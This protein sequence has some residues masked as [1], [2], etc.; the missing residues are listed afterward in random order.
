VAK[1]GKEIVGIIRENMEFGG[2]AKMSMLGV[3]PSFRGK[4]IGK[5][6]LKEFLRDLENK[7]VHHFYLYSHKKLVEAISLYEANGFKHL[8]SLKNF[9]LN[10]DF[11]LMSKEK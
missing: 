3:I 1:I 10:E 5:S 9:W 4:G 2:V 11:I 6:L 8:C 7:G